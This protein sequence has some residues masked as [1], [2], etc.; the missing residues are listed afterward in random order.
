MLLKKKKR[1]NVSKA[2]STL[3]ALF[4]HQLLFMQWQHEKYKQFSVPVASG[5]GGNTHTNTHILHP[6]SQVCV[7]KMFSASFIPQ[8]MKQSSIQY[9]FKFLQIQTATLK[10]KKNCFMKCIIA[11][12]NYGTHSSDMFLLLGSCYG[13]C[14]IP[15][16]L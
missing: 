2:S 11:A 10:E 7:T 6:D 3:E 9:H 14:G 15:K 4:M 16:S 1:L 13:N 8:L 5:M 12:D